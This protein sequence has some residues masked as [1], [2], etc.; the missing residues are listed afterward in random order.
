LP[1][2]I[3]GQKAIAFF[4]KYFAKN[5]NLISVTVKNN[6]NELALGYTTVKLF[7]D[8][9][10]R[11]IN[12]INVF[13]I[14]KIIKEQKATHLL[15]E[16]PYLGW[17]AFLIKKSTGVKTI[18][19]SHN[20]ESLRFKT[21]GKWWW[22]ILWQY[23]KWTHRNAD[24]N[25]FIQE[26][27]Y[28]YAIDQFKLAADKCLVVTYGITF[29]EPP[30]TEEKQACNSLIKQKHAIAENEKVLLFSGSF[31][32]QPNLDAL[33]IIEN[34][35]CPLWDE[36]GFKYRVIICGPGIEPSA[37]R[38]PLIIIAGFVDKIEPYFTGADV[39]VNPVIE[40]GGIKTKLVEALGYNC[41][42]VSTIEG[43][44]GIPEELCNGKL[45]LAKNGDWNSFAEQI[46]SVAQYKADVNPG[47]Y[48][49]F[50]WGHITKKAAEFIESYA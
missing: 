39:F 24:F 40:G 26:A 33:K 46:V 27:D 49:R 48:Q 47:F 22:S 2:K 9:P 19:R 17:L 32:Y 41:N 11:Y 30:S 45:K 35:L 31:H 44:T 12:L 38:H 8:S 13:R 23:E 4:Y 21:L 29:K 37:V 7:S 1:A 34:K 28:K 5:V 20:I 14:R 42:A 50:Y 25:F 6:S 43:A 36:E 3:G 15:I 16:H 18:V 10:L